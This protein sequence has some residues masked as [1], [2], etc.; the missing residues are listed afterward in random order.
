[1][2]KPKIRAYRRKHVK[3]SGKWSRRNR[4]RSEAKKA[5]V[6][7]GFLVGCAV[8]VSACVAV[9]IVVALTILDYADYHFDREA[10]VAV[11]LSTQ[12]SISPDKIDAGSVAYAVE[13]WDRRYVEYIFFL[14]G[15]EGGSSRAGGIA[16]L[17]AMKHG[18]DH[19][20]IVCDT[21]TPNIYA[22][23]RF[24]QKEGERL[25]VGTFLI[26]CDPYKS[27]RAVFVARS[28]GMKAFPAPLLVS[29]YQSTKAKA[30]IV[31][32][33]TWL[34]ILHA[35]QLWFESVAGS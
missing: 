33:E 2:S 23:L 8:A 5:R 30:E 22:N 11:V 21:T 18:V 9:F 27:K 6:T 15:R 35:M 31:A 32:E 12:D 1:M 3:Y 26:V 24:A 19:R 16:R 20:K 29:K 10:D 4:E 14:G 34:Y 13:L 25:G 28:M 7:R 17:Y